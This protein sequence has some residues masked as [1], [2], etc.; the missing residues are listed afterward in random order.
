MQPHYR[1]KTS[2]E[3]H[4]SSIMTMA[5]SPDGNY[6][7]AGSENGT[8]IVYAKMVR[9]W[10]PLS[11]FVDLSPLTSIA[12]HPLN[13]RILYCGFESGDVHTLLLPPTKVSETL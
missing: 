8:L 6:L 5:F 3:G 1:Y 12:W 13:K 4:D 7:A 10:V 11:R 9:G 2:L